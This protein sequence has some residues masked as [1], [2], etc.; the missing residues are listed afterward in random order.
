[1]SKPIFNIK[2]SSISGINTSWNTTINNELLILDIPK[3]F[4]G[5]GNHISPED[6]FAASL[7]NCFLATFKVIAEKSKLNFESIDVHVELILDE[8]LLTS[9]TVMKKANFK[10]YL[11]SPDNIDRA[12]RILNKTPDNCMILNSVK[13][14]FTFQYFIQ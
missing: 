7:G 5:P 10:I 8:D 2:T 1:M 13:T 6:L 12:N 9:K 11:F 4:Q 14:E 3:D